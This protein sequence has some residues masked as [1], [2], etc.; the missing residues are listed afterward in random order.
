MPLPSSKDLYDHLPPRSRSPPSFYHTSRSTSTHNLYDAS[1]FDPYTRPLTDRYSTDDLT[2]FHSLDRRC[3]RRKTSSR[4]DDP[5]FDY[6]TSADYESPR[7]TRVAESRYRE[8]GLY[9]DRRYGRRPDEGGRPAPGRYRECDSP[10]A[11]RY[12]PYRTISRSANSVYRSGASL[13][14]EYAARSY[15]KRSSPDDAR[16]NASGRSKAGSSPYER[17]SVCS[18]AS[19]AST[20]NPPVCTEVYEYAEKSELYRS[21]GARETKFVYLK[22]PTPQH[23]TQVCT[24]RDRER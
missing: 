14:R 9:S 16:S 10:Y 13:V 22:Q 17:G 11:G 23:C 1:P 8:S 15:S 2:P 7:P 24:Q 5:L 12:D 3:A 4:F 20:R 18:R 19:R 6:P 21:E